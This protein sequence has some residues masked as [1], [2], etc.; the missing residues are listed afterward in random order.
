MTRGHEW[1]RLLPVVPLILGLGFLA[2]DWERAGETGADD[3]SKSVA[4]TEGEGSGDQADPNFRLPALWV[5]DFKT[6]GINDCEHDAIISEIV[7]H[8]IEPHLLAFQDEI[9]QWSVR[10]LIGRCAEANKV[11]RVPEFSDMSRYEL[12]FWNVSPS[13]NSAMG[14]LTNELSSFNGQ[15]AEY[16]ESGG[17]IILWGMH[18]V[19]AVLGDFFPADRY[20]PDLPQFPNPNFGPGDFLWEP[21]HLRTT[22]DRAGRGDGPGAR[23]MAT[24]CSGIIALEATDLALGEGFPAGVL[25]PTGYDPE[26]TAIWYEDWEGWHN[27]RGWH[28]ANAPVGIP[29]LITAGLD[30]LYTFV[31]N[32]WAWEDD[33]AEACGSSF[34]SP[35]DGKPVVMRYQ[36]QEGAR[37]K[38]VWIGTPLYVFDEDHREDLKQMMRLLTDWILEEE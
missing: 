7:N 34:L 6:A 4:P 36:D 29:P 26:K 2:C 31:S 10:N 30:T 5:D 9:E 37:G 8:A 35:L 1:I 32:S 19:G 25:D 11:V 27:E 38:I 17:N 18:D 14:K 33:L 24:E 22:F 12:L 28:G 15:L 20:V 23:Q 16:V 21:M 3:A 13:P